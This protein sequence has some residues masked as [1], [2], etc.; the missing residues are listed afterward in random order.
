MGVGG[1]RPDP[2]AL[3]VGKRPGAHCRKLIE[4]TTVYCMITVQLYF[5][6]VLIMVSS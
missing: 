3:P 2:T 6:F 5:V 4:T 1:H